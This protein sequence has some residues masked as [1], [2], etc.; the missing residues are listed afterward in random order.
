MRNGVLVDFGRW[1]DKGRIGNSD[2]SQIEEGKEVKEQRMGYQ[3]VLPRLESYMQAVCAVVVF[4]RHSGLDLE[5]K[6]EVEVAAAMNVGIP[7]V[8][9]GRRSGG[10]EFA[11]AAK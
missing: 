2:D 11:A 1:N 4:Q 9:V 7:L 10:F 6:S 5:A 3:P 8:V